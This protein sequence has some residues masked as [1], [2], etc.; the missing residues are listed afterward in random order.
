VENS[1]LC[2]LLNGVNG[3][4]AS[5]VG[6]NLGNNSLVHCAYCFYLVLVDLEFVLS[7]STF[8]SCCGCIE[9]LQ[10]SPSISGATRFC[11]FE[12]NFEFLIELHFVGNSDP[13]LEVS[14]HRNSLHS[15]R[16][17]DRFNR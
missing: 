17:S 16:S 5:L 11:N 3:Y 6:V 9:H 12:F 1:T 10:R 2:E 4:I 13:V 7:R 14:V 15:V 8:S